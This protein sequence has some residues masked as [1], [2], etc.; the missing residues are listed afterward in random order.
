MPQS[1][2]RSSSKPVNC[3]GVLGLCRVGFEA[4]LAAELGDLASQGGESLAG[5]GTVGP[6]FAFLSFA[7]PQALRDLAGWF[8]FRDHVFARQRLFWIERIVDLPQRDRITPILSALERHGLRV[9][10]LA[11]EFPDSDAARPL[12]GFCRRFEEPLT[13]AMQAAGRLR[14]DQTGLPVLHLLF[15]DASTVWVT[16][17]ESGDGASWPMGIPRLRIPKEAPSRSALKLVEALE[18]LLT[19]RE[20]EASLRASQRAVDLGAAPGGWSWHLARRGLRVVAIDNGPLAPAAHAT[21]MI[22]H[23]RADGFTWRPTRPVDWMVC[24]M[25]AQPSRVAQLVAEWVATGRCRHCIF[26]LKLP[27]KRRR[28]ELERCR[29]MIF[30]L[31]RSVAPI[32]LRFKHLY[33][34]REEVTGYLTLKR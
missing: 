14:P 27:M 33:H 31:T 17:V 9:S 7:E 28:E 22:Q 25:V 12:S 1:H 13:Q 32:D 15:T 18:V 11:L 4:E 3:H 24:D 20:R 29:A 5:P 34:D 19:D 21:A 30:K 6:G 26:N 16:L 8:P 2:S 23:L 10:A